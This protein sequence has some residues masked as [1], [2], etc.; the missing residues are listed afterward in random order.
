MKKFITSLFLVFVF[1]FSVIAC[2]IDDPNANSGNHTVTFTLEGSVISVTFTQTL[3]SQTHGTW[4]NQTYEIH[5]NVTTPFTYE[6]EFSGF[7]NH[8]SDKITRMCL[9]YL[10]KD[11]KFKILKDI[12]NPSFNVASNTGEKRALFGKYSVYSTFGYKSGEILAIL[13]YFETATKSTHN[14][15]TMLNTKYTN[16]NDIPGLLK[17]GVYSNKNPL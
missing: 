11:G 13:A 1:V 15:N 4:N 5:A 3:D 7:E 12:K 8:E 10:N 9:L 6:V 14:L 2:F 16:L 17:L